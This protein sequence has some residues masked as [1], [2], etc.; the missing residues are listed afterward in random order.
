MRRRRSKTVKEAEEQKCKLRHIDYLS[1]LLHARSLGV[2]RIDIYP[3]DFCAGLHLGHIKIRYAAH[4]ER[5][6]NAKITS[7]LR[8]IHKHEL[9]IAERM[10]IVHRLRSL[11]EE[12]MIYFGS[13]NE[14]VYYVL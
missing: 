2:D 4:C 5:E 6:G 3:C 11:L 14:T 12:V 7:L 1:A 9:L 10:K 13:G 8:R